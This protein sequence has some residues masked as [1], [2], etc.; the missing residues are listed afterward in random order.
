M[1][2]P[3]L[4]FPLQAPYPI[5]PPSETIKVLPP[6]THSHLMALESPY[7]GASSLPWTQGLPSH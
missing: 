3:F 6:P 2:S 7:A 4:V 5:P 1:L